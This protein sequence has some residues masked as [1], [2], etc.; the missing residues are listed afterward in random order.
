M[1]TVR[2]DFVSFGTRDRRVVEIV[3]DERDWS[4][5]FCNGDFLVSVPDNDE[6]I[7]TI[8][9]PDT[10]MRALYEAMRDYYGDA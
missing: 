2:D 4:L 1:L 7:I 9:L 3:D 6:G 8:E 10:F 5:E